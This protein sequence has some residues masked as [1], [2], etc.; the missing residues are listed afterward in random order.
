MIFGALFRGIRARHIPA[1][2]NAP[3]RLIFK[4][5]RKSLSILTF[6]APLRY[7]DF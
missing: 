1:M 3:V 2:T 6:G 7:Y 4:T 5:V